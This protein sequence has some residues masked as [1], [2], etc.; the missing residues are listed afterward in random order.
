MVDGYIFTELCS[1]TIAILATAEK[2][3]AI[4]VDCP[5]GFEIAIINYSSGLLIGTL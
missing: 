5:V 2:D 3:S 1:N 4:R